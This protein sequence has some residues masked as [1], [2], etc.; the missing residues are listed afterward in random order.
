MMRT[1]LVK[2]LLSGAFLVAL[3]FIP[4]PAAAQ[5]L[6]LA[7]AEVRANFKPGQLVQFDLTVSN[8]GGT[9]V[10][11]RTSV[12]DLWYNQK[13]NE[14]VF[15]PPGSLPR[16]ASDWIEF[17]PRNFAVP[18]H[19]TGKVKVVIT[20]PRGATGG[21]YAVLFAESKPELARAAT[22]ER[23]AVYTNMRLGALIL[24][25][26]DGTENYNI[27]VTDA[28]FTPPSRNQNLELELQLANKSNSHIFPRVR[29]AILNANKELVAR[30]ESEP[31]RFFPDQKDSMKVSW[32]GSLPDGDYMAIL[33]VVYGKDKI[34]TQEVRFSVGQNQQKAAR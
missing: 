6:G 18:A 32:P 25:S 26:A 10:V 33:T 9:P 4:A 16:S 22:S 12:M 24:L 29:L 7:P 21:Y 1:L 15:G 2:L 17:V 34:Y 8:D 19:A 31:R 30:A 14:K 5:S 28:K 3:L 20:P 23:K 13:T 11:M 27:E